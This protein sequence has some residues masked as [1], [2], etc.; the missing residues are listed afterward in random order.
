MSRAEKGTL[1][2]YRSNSGVRLTELA[3]ELDIPHNTLGY[4]ERAEKSG[5]V[6]FTL[7]FTREY[8]A[9]VRAVAER[10]YTK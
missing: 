8:R 7:K 9:G 5:Y 4:M 1:Q 2:Y 10:V 6:Q 3:K